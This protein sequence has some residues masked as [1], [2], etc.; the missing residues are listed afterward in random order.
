MSVCANLVVTLLLAVGLGAC[1]SA[2]PTVDPHPFVGSA[3]G[4]AGAT[5]PVG[6]AGAPPTPAAAMDAGVNDALD[7][8][9][10]RGD[11]R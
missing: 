4:S 3:M 10:L 9:K 6:G 8:S 2:Q 11:A 1:D 7:T 5:G